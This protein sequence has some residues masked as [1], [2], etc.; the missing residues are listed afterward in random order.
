MSDYTPTTEAVRKIYCAAPIVTEGN[1][2]SDAAV[3][4]NIERFDRWL[5]ELEQGD[6]HADEAHHSRS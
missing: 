4:R 5:A 1:R 2:L 6:H 3:G